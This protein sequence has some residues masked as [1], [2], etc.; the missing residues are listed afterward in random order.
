MCQ[1]KLLKPIYL[2]DSMTS[3]K[4]CSL[5]RKIRRSKEIAKKL[6]GRRGGSNE[7][8]LRLRREIV[9]AKLE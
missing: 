5:E 9:K 1:V 4:L 3:D 6:R 2:M 7:E 8:Y